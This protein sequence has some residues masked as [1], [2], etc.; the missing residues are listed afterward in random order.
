MQMHCAGKPRRFLGLLTGAS[1][2]AIAS[3][4][5]AQEADAEVG[6][7]EIVVTAQKREQNLQVVPLAVS[8]SARTRSSSL[9]SGMPRI[10]RASRR[11]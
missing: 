6:L 8:A 2:A 9:A 1:L 11:T 5:F 4:A 3:P 10:C 7:D